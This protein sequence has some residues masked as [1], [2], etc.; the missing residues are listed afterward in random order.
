[1]DKKRVL[2]IDNY[3][4]FTYNLVQ[5]LGMLGAE[6]SVFRNDRLDLADI[7]R[8]DPDNILISPGPKRPSDA[9]LSKEIILEYGRRISILGVCLGHQCIGEA[10]G[11]QIVRA[12]KVM[13]G[14]TSVI[15][16]DGSGVLNGIDSPFEGARYHSLVVDGKNLPDCLQVTSRTEDEVIMGIRHREY[17]VEGI[18]FHPESFMTDHGLKMLQNFLEKY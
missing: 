18:Q 10:Y 15:Y 6:I 14:K 3:D 4:S 17:P 5:S 13:H 8:V 1:M 2:V 11:G 9:G 7:E 12:G 16:H